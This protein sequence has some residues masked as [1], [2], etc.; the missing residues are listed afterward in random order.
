M[1][2][3]ST[4]EEY[5]QKLVNDR[6]NISIIDYVKAVN[7]MKYKIDISF[8]D[9]LLE[10][11]N[12][13][14]CCIHHE[15]LEKY[16]I[17]SKKDSTNNIRR[18]LEQHNFNEGE[19]FK[20]LN[21]ERFTNGGRNNKNQYCLHPKAFKLCLMRSKNTKKYAHYYI[22]LE[23][24]IKHYNDYQIFLLNTYN[25]KLKDKIK[26]NKIIIY[27]QNNEIKELHSKVDLLLKNNEKTL[28]NNNQL[29][30]D[31]KKL[32]DKLDHANEQLEDIQDELSEVK[33]ELRDTTIK[34]DLS[35]ED[36]VPK[37]KS[38]QIREYFVLL[39]TINNREK[40]K[41]Y[42]LRGQKRYVDRKIEFMNSSYQVIKSY[43]CIPN[44]TNLFS[45][46]KEQMKDKLDICNNKLNIIDI[47]HNSFVEKINQIYQQKNHVI[48]N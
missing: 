9:E 17:I 15:L 33:D 5:N 34:L 32:L 42:V 29:L 36:R 41:Y 3:N 1:I 37:T 20:P 43:E 44:A 27:Q 13:D 26:E 14:D 19:D 22:L 48:M 8:I 28:E 4:I 25:I 39:Q 45:R 11:V 40:Y 6:I 30:Q 38:I 21:I 18:L 24:C 10:L 23:D 2:H 47:D 46:I 31:N 35:L 12:R 7:D 16:K